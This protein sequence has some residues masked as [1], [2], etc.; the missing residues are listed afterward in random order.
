M[1]LHLSDIH[2]RL[3]ITAFRLPFPPPKQ[4][5]AQHTEI[6]PPSHQVADL[7]TAMFLLQLHGSFESSVLIPNLAS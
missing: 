5:H 2:V 7:H 4:H 6:M 1:E 3:C